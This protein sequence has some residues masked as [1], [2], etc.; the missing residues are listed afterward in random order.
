MTT[1]A[2]DAPKPAELIE[3]QAPR[4][5]DD[6]KVSLLTLCGLALV[7]GIMTGVGA[8]AFRALIGFAHNAL[9]NGR[10]SFIYDANIPEAPSRFGD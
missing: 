10:L 3:L 9:Y 8:V 4:L 5:R 7:I 6:R 1:I 2:A